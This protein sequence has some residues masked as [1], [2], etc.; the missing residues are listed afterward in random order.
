MDT[1]LLETMAEVLCSGDA[2][3]EVQWCLW[4]G[5]MVIAM[6]Q[7]KE[8]IQ[9]GDSSDIVFRQTTIIYLFIHLPISTYIYLQIYLYIVA[10]NP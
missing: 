4:S 9:I 1:L 8:V 7:E 6:G 10:F 3:R 2:S 5:G